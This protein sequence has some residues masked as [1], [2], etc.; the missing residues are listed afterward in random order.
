[1][2][3][4]PLK[5]ILSSSLLPQTDSRLKDKEANSLTQARSI[6]LKGVQRDIF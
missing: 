3:F 6:N 2:N 1:M 5:F 4:W